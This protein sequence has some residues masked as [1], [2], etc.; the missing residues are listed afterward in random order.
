MIVSAQQLKDGIFM[1]RTLRFSVGLLI[2]SVCAIPSFAATPV[3][4]DL[5]AQGQAALA[6]SK[7]SEALDLFETAS[8]ADPK[9]AAAFAGMA[10]SYDALGLGGK[11][12]RYYREALELTPNDVGLLESQALGMISKGNVAKAQAA[13]DRIKKVC[14][15]VACPAQSRVDAALAKARTQTSMNTSRAP[16]ILRKVAKP[17]VAAK[18]T[19]KTQPKSK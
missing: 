19:V 4:V 7:A 12:L 1:Q 17:A 13:Y 18:P 14:A 10:R 9:N 15:K 8:L 16:A 6:A 2:A 3:S 5:V 11:A